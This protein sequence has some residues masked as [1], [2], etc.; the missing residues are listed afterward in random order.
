MITYIQLF[1][2]GSVYLCTILHWNISDF[3]SPFLQSP[4]SKPPYNLNTSWALTFKR[5]DQDRST[6]VPGEPKGYYLDFYPSPW[7]LHNRYCHKTYILCLLLQE[8]IRTEPQREMRCPELCRGQPQGSYWRLYVAIT[9]WLKSSSV[10]TG[11]SF[12]E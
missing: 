7:N 12:S 1:M 3:V 2:Q 5:I 11:Y 6:T 10:T 8:L 4:Q 9:K